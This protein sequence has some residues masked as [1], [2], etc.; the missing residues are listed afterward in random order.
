M[1]A[2]GY[3]GFGSLYE[4]GGVVEAACRGHARRRAHD[5]HAAGPS[6]LAREAIRPELCSAR[7]K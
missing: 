4:G 5:I 3:A 2:D 1:Q 7:R 6:P